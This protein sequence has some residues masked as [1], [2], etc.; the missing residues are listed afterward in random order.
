[1]RCIALPLPPKGTTLARRVSHTNAGVALAHDSGNFRR[2]IDF[3]HD[4]GYFDPELCTE[5]ALCEKVRFM[6]TAQA[7]SF[8]CSQYTETTGFAFISP[9]VIRDRKY[10]VRLPVSP[11][12]THLKLVSYL[13]QSVWKTGTGVN[14]RVQTWFG[15]Y[16]SH[17]RLAQSMSRRGPNLKKG[18]Y[19]PGRGLARTERLKS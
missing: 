11:E 17:P 14:A 6:V 7:T 10:M 18:G 15:I 2:R 9:W 5:V 13:S 1:M 8:D 12:G 3:T 4:G 16:I 19:D